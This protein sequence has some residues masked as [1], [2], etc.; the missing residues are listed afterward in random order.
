MQ[1]I[2]C[3]DRMVAKGGGSIT[4][5]AALL[6]GKLPNPTELRE[7]I[8]GMRA[9]RQ[10]PEDITTVDLTGTGAQDTASATHVMK[11]IG[12]AGTRIRA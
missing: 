3:E 5:L 1:V 8:A 9:G 12:D 11:T 7:V 2:L 6:V 10:A 4:G